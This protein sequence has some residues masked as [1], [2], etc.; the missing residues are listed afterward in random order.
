MSVLNLCLRQS[1]DSPRHLSLPRAAWSY[2]PPQRTAHSAQ[3]AV[4]S[5]ICNCMCRRF[6]LSFTFCVKILLCLFSLLTLAHKTI[7][8]H[9]SVHVR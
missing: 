2:T 5:V 9:Y 3:T 1:S 8:R 6:F 4:Y 7:M